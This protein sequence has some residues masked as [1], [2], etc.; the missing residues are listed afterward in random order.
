M[1]LKCI[2]A[3]IL[4]LFAYLSI[5]GNHAYAES[6]IRFIKKINLVCLS[7]RLMVLFFRVLRRGF[8]SGSGVEFC[9]YRC[10]GS[11]RQSLTDVNFDVVANR[12]EINERL[13]TPA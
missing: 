2:L 12:M 11:H 7:I 8:R 6:N 10:D 4:L 9:R 5:I 13:S 1:N 3:F